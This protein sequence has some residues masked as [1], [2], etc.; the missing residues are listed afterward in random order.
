MIPQRVKAPWWRCRLMAL[1]FKLRNQPKLSKPFWVLS[2]LWA[3]DKT[4]MALSAFFTGL[5][6]GAISKG[7]E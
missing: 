6:M 2:R 3:S 4:H 1:A 5:M 7:E